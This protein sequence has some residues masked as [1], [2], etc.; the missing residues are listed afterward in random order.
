MS[1]VQASQTGIWT[2]NAL[3]SGLPTGANLVGNVSV[4]LLPG[5]AVSAN[6]IGLVN[7]NSDT[8]IAAGTAPAK[9]LVTAAVFNT[10]LP[11]VTNGQTVALQVDASGRL[12]TNSSVTIGGLSTGANVIGLVNTNAD[13]SIG[14]GT[15]PAKALIAGG[16]YNSSAPTPSTGQTLA[17][18]LD[19]AGRL[20]TNAGSLALSGLLP[21]TNSIGAVYT[22]GVE[23][24]VI[25]TVTNA[26]TYGAN[27]VLGGIMT[28]ANILPTTLLQGKLDSIMLKFKGSLQTIEFNVGIFTSSPAGTF[29]DNSTAAINVADSTLL[30][31]VY[32]LVAF[33][34]TL[35]TH[36]IYNLD[37]IG[38]RVTGTGT[39]LFAVVV[40]LSSTA[41]LASTTDL[42]VRLGMSW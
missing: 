40:A 30:L 23:V 8:G 33:R 1:D 17:L 27:K 15:A 19:A 35:G 31:G 7:T 26:G 29:T 9:A 37:G 41:A 39:S 21:S 22:A 13:A 6:N 11:T 3:S 42:Q 25:P 32:R 38:Q 20:I 2:I 36:T 16:V 18:Q 5:L 34:S 24:E 4:S 28:F 14:A 12:I 10:A